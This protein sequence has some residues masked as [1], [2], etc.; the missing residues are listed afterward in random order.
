MDRVYTQVV[1]SLTA[2]EL[3]THIRAKIRKGSV[4]Y[5]D[6]FKGYRSLR[7]YGKHHTLNHSKSLVDK[8][9]K[10]HINVYEPPRVCKDFFKC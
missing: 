1:E 3:I 8:R 2:E 4:Y 5:T 7:R 9:T 10:N 6:A